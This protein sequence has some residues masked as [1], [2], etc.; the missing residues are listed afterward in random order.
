[1]NY[2][3]RE[4]FLC[5]FHRVKN[6]LNNDTEP[7]WIS[8][9]KWYFISFRNCHFMIRPMPKDSQRYT[10]IINI[11]TGFERKRM[12]MITFE[13]YMFCV[14]AL[15]SL[16]K[17][18]FYIILLSPFSCYKLCVLF[19]FQLEKW[20]K[21]EMHWTQAKVNVSLSSTNNPFLTRIKLS[22]PWTRISLRYDSLSVEM[23]L[24]FS[25]CNFTNIVWIMCASIHIWILSNR[26]V[27]NFG[28]WKH[29]VVL[30]IRHF[31]RL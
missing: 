6:V 12:Q 5:I 16:I 4:S 29:F 26:K 19:R 11:K 3:S 1:M 28:L 20:K 21:N 8:F 25:E 2:F 27:L 17:L 13:N 9:E 18:K 30:S 31:N 23:S 10:E 7:I 14:Y 24:A 22:R 15:V